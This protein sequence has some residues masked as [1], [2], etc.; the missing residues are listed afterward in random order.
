[1]LK[2]QIKKYSKYGVGIDMSKDWIQA[3]ISA[4]PLEGGIKILKVK[5]FKNCPSGH[6]AFKNWIEKNRKDKSLSYQIVME[7]TGVYHE[8]LLYYL[9]DAGLNV[10]LEV[11]SR[12]KKYLEFIGQKSKNDKLDGIG[13]ATLA[14]ERKLKAWKP[15]SKHIRELRTALRHRKSLIQSKNQFKNQLH[16]IRTSKNYSDEAEKSLKETIKFLKAQIIKI[17]TESIALAKRDNELMEKVNLIANSV[18]GLGLISVLTT[19]AET[20]GF[21]NFNSSKQLQSYAGYDIV[22]SSS[23]KR[24]GKTRISKKGNTHL[25]TG[26]YMPALSIIRSKVDPFYSLYDRLLKRNGGIKKKALVAVQRKLLVLIYTLW[27]K[28]E[29]F[30]ISYYH[31]SVDE[32]KMASL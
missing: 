17:E 25:R 27:K 26:M 10:S 23:G 28:N 16:A 4:M 8:K 14:C 13:I 7:V 31:A 12:V 1:M 30:D 21:E 29:A 22:E 15:A 6:N 3:C 18:K 32:N 24:E 11:P 9:Y 19:V 20:N 2:K 5:K